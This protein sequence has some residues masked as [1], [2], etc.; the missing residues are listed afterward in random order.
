MMLHVSGGTS[1]MIT[2][3]FTMMTSLSRRTKTDIQNYNRILLLLAG[4]HVLQVA[5]AMSPS[6]AFLLEISL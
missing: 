5:V 6:L 3:P 1:T 4:F 2:S